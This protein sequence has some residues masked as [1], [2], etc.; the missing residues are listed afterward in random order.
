MK[1]K[2]FFTVLLAFFCVAMFFGWK[3]LYHPPVKVAEDEIG[4]QITLDTKEDFGLLII[5]YKDANG[6]GGQGGLSNANKTLLKHNDQLFF[7]LPKQAFDNPSD[8]ENLSIQFSIITEYVDPNF[9]N[10]YPA[11]YTIPM[12]AIPLKASFGESYSIK[13]FGDVTNGYKAVLEE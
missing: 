13:V 3:I 12:D 4:L 8:V 11:E 10:I 7:T 5:D 2:N 1:L 6:S 9:D